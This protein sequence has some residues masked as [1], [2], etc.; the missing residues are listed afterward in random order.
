MAP[1]TAHI[2]TIPHPQINF[3]KIPPTIPK[4]QHPTPL[5]ILKN[6]QGT[7]SNVGHGTIKK[8]PEGLQT[9]SGVQG[10][11]PQGEATEQKTCTI[12]E[13]KCTLTVTRQQVQ[14]QH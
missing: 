14:R 2:N 5:K 11:E 4:R 9:V 10:G 13:K 7:M 6:F 3:S 1:S 12:A 8:T